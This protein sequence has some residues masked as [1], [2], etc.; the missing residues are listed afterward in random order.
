MKIKSTLLGLAALLLAGMVQAQEWNF[1]SDPAQEKK[2]R[3]FNAAYTDFMGSEQ[4]VE[5]TKP[6][7]WLLVNVPE[8]NES[9]Y[10][11]GVKVYDGAAKVTTDE[12]Q[13]RIY[14]DSVMAIYNK[15]AEIYDN[16]KN[17]IENKAYYGYQYFKGDKDKLAEPIADFEKALELNGTIS[18]QL[19]A[20]YFD[21]VYRNYAYN[22]AYSGEEILTIHDK[23][24]KMLDEAAVDGKDVS[25][26]KATL[27]QLLVAMEL[28]DCD[29]IEN[30]MGPK[31]TADPTNEV[32]ADQIFKYSVQYKCFSS[33]AFLQALEMKH[34]KE[35]SFS[36]SQVI[37]MRYLQEDNSAKAEEM[38]NQALKLAENNTQKADAQMELAKI[39]AK[40]GK[41]SAARTAAKEVANLDPSRTSDIYSMIGG[42]YMNS[43]NECKGGESRVKDYSIYIAAYNAYQKAG[44]SSGMAQARSRFPSKEELF[45]EG[46]QVGSTINTGCWIGETVTLAS[47]D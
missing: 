25:S 8:L 6:L 13:K 47:R 24:N 37:A 40:T 41:K 5:A 29:F 30:T 20:A 1:P 33:K 39:Y 26:Q 15:R 3:E 45:T 4:F 28:I 23:V 2:A 10:Q 46:L 44:D 14:Q 9:I 18:Y 36:T 31:L 35:P 43:F 17:W 22:Q 27:E 12:A 32:L 42:M 11:N 21:L 16:E 7:N 19:I 38:W 34:A